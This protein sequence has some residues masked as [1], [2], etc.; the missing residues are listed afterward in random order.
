LAGTSTE[1][2]FRLN[3][4]VEEV[5]KVKAKLNKDPLAKDLEKVDSVNTQAA[6]FKKFFANLP[7]PLLPFSF[8]DR[9]LDADGM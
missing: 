1:G 8:Y 6:I 7:E 5:E 4:S 2:I 3:A 9:F